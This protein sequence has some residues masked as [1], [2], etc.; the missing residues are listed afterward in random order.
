MERPD[1]RPVGRQG[2]VASGGFV[3]GTRVHG[4]DGMQ[5]HASLVVRMDPGEIPIDQLGGGEIAAAHRGVTAVDGEFGPR[6]VEVAHG[7]SRRRGAR[8]P[9]RRPEGRRGSSPAVPCVS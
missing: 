1:E 6:V 3:A 2:R 4:H 5:S 7:V 8:R 9:R